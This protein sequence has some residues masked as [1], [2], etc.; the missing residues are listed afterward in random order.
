MINHRQTTIKIST[1]PA[2]SGR[3]GVQVHQKVL[4]ML[5]CVPGGLHMGYVHCVTY[6]LHHG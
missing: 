3:V 6:R 1:Y 2:K 4:A 5:S